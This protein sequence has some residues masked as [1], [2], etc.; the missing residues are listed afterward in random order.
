MEADSTLGEMPGLSPSSYVELDMEWGLG[1]WQDV[2]SALLQ[3][4]LSKDY[5]Q[6]VL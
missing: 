3:K 4:F 2:T 6:L 1:F 5:R